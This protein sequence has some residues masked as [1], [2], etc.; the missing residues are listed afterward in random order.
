MKDRL[1]TLLKVAISLG[2]IAYLLFF[3]VDLKEV[4]RAFAGAHIG[5][6]LLALALYFVAI[7]LGCHKWQRLLRAQGLHIPLPNLLSFTFVGLFF[8][9]FLL[10]MVAG[11]VVRGYDLA[12]STERVPEA[13][14][15]VVVD[16]LIGLLAFATA[17]TVM[18]AF[19]VWGLGR[20][21]LKGVAFIVFLAFAGFVLLFASILSRR[22]RRLMER[23]FSLGPLQRLAP[24]YHQLSDA[25]QAYRDHL[26]SLAG[27]FAISLGVLLITNVVN[28]LLAMA[29][30][31]GV[32]LLYIFIFNPLVAFAPILIPS[33]G[34]LGVNQG[35][36]DLLYA[37][38]G[39][40][41]SSELAITFSLMMQMVIY[42]SSLPGGVL[43]LM[44]RRPAAQA[45]G[46]ET[47]AQTSISHQQE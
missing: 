10:P 22:L 12:R 1:L 8:G 15:S 46:A 16:K 25:M 9:N 17:G 43:W 35:A 32:P 11:D 28:W 23:I 2:L 18:I 45:G 3:K 47:P 14:I 31:A 27:A 26:G 7:T 5:Y 36:Y 21:D 39:G 4:G 29:V 6:F 40:T 42:L 20:S 44:K 37:T 30:G 38:L 13:A 24:I 19:A 41:T 33:I 34:G